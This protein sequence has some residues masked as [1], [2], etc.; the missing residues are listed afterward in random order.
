[1]AEEIKAAAGAPEAAA[2]DGGLEGGTYE[3]IRER[4]AGLGTDLRGRL[5][6]LNVARKEVFGSIETTLLGSERITTRNNCVPRDMVPVGNRIVFGYNVHIGLKTRTELE[7]VFAVYEYGN[8]TFQETGLDLLSDERF[9]R[10]FQDLY[11]YYT[12]TVLVK[13]SIIG[14]YL[15]MVFRTGKSITDVKTFKWLVK[16]DG[17]D[18]V[19]NRSDHE[20]RFPDQHQFEWK[21]TQ[22]EFQRAGEFPH[23]SIED[24]VFVETIGGDL[25]IKVEDNTA[26]GKGIYSEPVDN[27]DQ[28]L[29]DAEILYAAVGNIIL[30]KIRPYQEKDF[31]YLIFN[32]KTQQVVRMD[33]LHDACIL[34]PDDHGIIFSNGYYLQ[35]GDYKVFNTELTDM[36]FEQ[37]ISAPNGE[38]FQYLFYNRESGIYAV[39]SYNLIAQCVDTPIIC[40]GYSHLDNGELILFKADEEPKKSHVLQIWQTPFVGSDYPMTTESDS[41]LYKIGNKEI[42]RC[43]SECQEVLNLIKKEDSYANLF[44][45]ISKLAAGIADGYFWLDK[46]EGCFIREVITG[47]QNTAAAAVEEY[48]KVARLRKSS[49]AAVENVNQK[50]QDLLREL[51][52]SVFD[53]V[54]VFVGGLA[55]LRAIRGEII[56]CREL[57]YVDLGQI[58]AAEKEVKEKADELAEGCI[59]FLLKPEGL[60]PY[61]ERVQQQRSSIASVHKSSDGED[62]GKAIGQTS[63][64]LELLIE[65]VSNLKIDDPTQSTAIIESISAI[66]STLNQVKSA[67]RN[68]MKELQSTEGAAEFNAQIKLIDQAVTNYLDVADTP[69]KCDEYLTK[70]MVQIEE[71]EGKFADFDEYIPVLSGKRD[72]VYSAFESKKLSLREKRD[73][74]ALALQNAGERIVKGIAN[75]LK[76]FTDIN[77]INGYFASDLMAGKVRDIIEELFSLGDPVKADDLQS[78]FKTIREDAVRQLKDKNE[79]FVGGKDVIRMGEH[80]FS[81]NTQP[82]DL[83]I[84][85]KDDEMFYHLTGTDFMHPV[86]DA[87]LKDLRQVWEQE[88]PSE[89]GVVYRSEYLAYTMLKASIEGQIEPVATLAAQSV[90]ELTPLVQ[91]FMAPRYQEGYVK[92]VHDHDAAILLRTLLQLHESLGL[93]IFRPEERALA[94]I[95]WQYCDD[96]GHKE[97][98]RARLSGLN[99]VYAVFNATERM[100]HYAA[101]TAPAIET[102]RASLGRF[103]GADISRASRYLCEEI[104]R[105]EQFVISAE[106]EALVKGFKAL[107]KEKKAEERWGNSLAALADNLVARYDL[108]HDWIAAY[109]EETGSQGSGLFPEEAAALLLTDSYHPRQVVSTPVS[110]HLEGLL[111][112]H[113]VIEKGTCRFDYIGFS[114]KIEGFIRDTLPQ[115]DAFR[116][117]KKEL[118]DAFRT[119]L[120]LEEFKPRVLTS[121]VRNQLID[122]VYLPL[123]GD[124]LAKQIGVVGEKKRTDLMGM[125]LLISPPG[126]GKTT[127]MEYIANRLGIIFMKVN[128]PA[129][130]HGVTS[131]DPDDAPNA[132]AREELKKLNLSF[133]MGN[134]VMIYIDDIQHCNPEFLQKFISLCDAQRKIEGVYNGISRTYDLRGKKVVVV[135]AGN[136]Y[137][138]SGEK[139]KIPDMLANRADTYNLGD[140]LRQNEEAFKLSYIENAMTSNPVLNRL[141][142]RSRKDI[143]QLVAVAQTGSR[144]GLDLESTYSAEELNEIVAVLQKLVEV[145]DIILRVNMEYIRSAAIADAYRTEPAFKLQGSYRNMNRIAEKVLAVMNSKELTSII[146]GSY[147]NDAQTLTSG[148][149][150]NLLKFRELN[151]YLTPDE[152][153]RWNNIKKTFGKNRLVGQDDKIGQV[154][155]QLSNF[156]DGLESIRHALDEGIK[157]SNTHHKVRE[158]RNAGTDF[159]RLDLSPATQDFLLKAIAHMEN[160]LAGNSGSNDRKP[161]DSPQSYQNDI[162]SL[163]QSQM[164]IMKGWLEPISN[165]TLQ[166]SANVEKLQIAVNR[167]MWLQRELIKRFLAERK[168]NKQGTGGLS[169]QDLLGEER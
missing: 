121:F 141:S 162:V 143:Y 97:L 119:T 150:A 152:Q 12:K 83:T 112:D 63:S 75:R 156:S 106:A 92:G 44:V 61:H 79:L 17:L 90:D 157:Q 48:E 100:E 135:M 164:E 84:V 85:R 93:L 159:G 52:A 155:L 37:R 165:T 87:R 62:L 23:I 73:K 151:G 166:E 88:L 28:T 26:T 6:K 20:Y 55:N 109:C 18:Y 125:L 19:D 133:E 13:F 134:N 65:I 91:Q 95:Y 41:I 60:A 51:R 36:L 76:T 34:L 169:E 167:A 118:T 71:L 53:S 86:Q 1:M 56:S 136:P 9:L 68:R 139:F 8:R 3:I 101:L 77:E 64:D 126:Y 127:L 15:Y 102:F 40:N 144:D 111:G 110:V 138:E 49:F 108:V 7:D 146:L 129:I 80:N 104:R 140:M 130:G 22:R 89:N 123:I 94:R 137:T 33:S 50:V 43:M 2:A 29:D 107:L 38:D 158:K 42:V 78:R 45:D 117:L 32:E 98:L 58:D 147:E 69:E 149:E 128:G 114:E 54:D 81:V 16:E 105:G 96:A 4:L 154:V 21:R 113:P 115:F 24:R 124:N 47:I 74:K 161:V 116:K 103:G 46:A 120:R 31:R 11:K 57:R 142:S 67:L 35:S 10:D 99:E 39:L 163:L 72:E 30:L 145:R 153:V 122:K 5:E 131:I 70:L 160:A 168:K 27:P 25:T 82:L 66:Y 148:A 14:P 59:T 132:G